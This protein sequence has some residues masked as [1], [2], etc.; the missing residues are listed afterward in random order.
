MI[1]KFL[2][3][4]FVERKTDKTTFALDLFLTFIT[5]SFKD[6]SSFALVKSMFNLIIS[7]VVNVVFSPTDI[8]YLLLDESYEIVKSVPFSG[9]SVVQLPS[10]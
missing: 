4:S 9:E 7:S 5:S 10:T 1:F 6:N 2:S 3:Y 8:L